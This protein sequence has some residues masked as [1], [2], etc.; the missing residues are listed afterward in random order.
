MISVEFGVW[1]SGYP[2]KK[3][4]HTNEKSMIKN[5]SL[6]VNDIPGFFREKCEGLP[7]FVAAF[8]KHQNLSDSELDEVQKMIDRIRRGG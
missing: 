4:C 2:W 3:D 1:S 6:T 7:A 8:T 5:G